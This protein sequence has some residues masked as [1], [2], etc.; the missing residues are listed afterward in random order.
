MPMN[1]MLTRCSGGSTPC[2]RSTAAICPTIS[3]ASRFRLTPSRAVK[4]NLQFTA[5]PTW[6]E[7]H[8]VARRPLTCGDRALHR[9]AV[10]QFHQIPYRAVTRNK[11]ARNLWKPHAPAF[12]HETSPIFERQR[13]DLIQPLNLLPVYGIK[14][15][16]T[17]VGWLPRPNSKICEFLQ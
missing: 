2:S 13:R 10:S 6:L 9:L 14:Q 16:L 8:I 11:L 7:T 17:T 15:L 1:T 5:Q 4:Q 12:L 3:P